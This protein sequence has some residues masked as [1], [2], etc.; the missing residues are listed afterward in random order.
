M[1][2]PLVYRLSLASVL[3]LITM[4]SISFTIYTLYEEALSEARLNLTVAAKS[5][6]RLINS[7]ARFNLEHV[8]SGREG[9]AAAATLDEIRNAHREFHGFAETGEMVVSERLGDRIHFLLWH[10]IDDPAQ[11][12]APSIAWDSANAEPMRRALAGKTGLITALDYR[13]KEVLAAYEPLTALGYGLVIKVDLEEIQS[14]F[15]RAVLI[16]FAAAFVLFAIGTWL[17]GRLTHPLIE[18]TIANERFTSLLLNS[19]AEG[20]YGLDRKGHC[21]FANEASCQLLGYEQKDLL[22]KNLHLLLHHSRADGSPYP[23]SECPSRRAMQAGTV[24]HSE[25]EMLWRR[26]G[27]SMPVDYHVHPIRENGEV[28]GAVVSVVDVSERKN[29]EALLRESE[30]LLRS[31]FNHAAVGIARVSPNGKLLRVNRKFCDILGYSKRSEVQ[32]KSIAEVTHPDDVEKS[33]ATVRAILNGERDTDSMEKRYLRKDGSVIWGAVTISLV[34]SKPDGKP[35]FFIAVLQ[36]IQ[37]R[38]EALA[39]L[40]KSEARLSEAQQVA[41]IGSWELD[42][43]G[44]HLLWSDEVFDIFEIDKEKFDASYEAFLN[45]IHP[46]DREMVNKAYNDSVEKH[47]YY[48]IM[49]R[50]LMSDGR[51]KFVQERGQSFYDEQGKPLRSIGTVQDLT[52]LHEMEEQLQQSQKMEA[53]GTLVGG[54]AHDF[55]NKL[56]AIT[57]NLFLAQEQVKDRPKA[58][59]LL[60]V[61]EEMGFEAADIIAQ[62]LAFARKGKLNKAPLLLVPFLKEASKLNRV[63]IPANIE[64]RLDYGKDQLPVMGDVTQLQQVFLNLVNNA[65]DALEKSENPRIDVALHAV[66]PD[67]AF[68]GRHPD[69]QQGIDYACISVSDNGSGI[70]EKDQPHIFDPFFTTKDVGK[71]TGLGL[72]MVYGVVQKHHGAIEV[73][74][75]AGKGSTFSVY[76]PLSPEAAGSDA[77]KQIEEVEKGQGETVLIADDEPNVLKTLS[78]VLTSLNYKVL[79][80]R[81][82]LEAVEMYGRNAAEID[83]VILD[84]VMPGLMGREAAKRIREIRQDVKLLYCSGHDS[85]GEG[86]EELDGVEVLEKPCVLESMSRTIRQVLEGDA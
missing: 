32:G 34:R 82:G 79:T 24:L 72:A 18:R 29:A 2:N 10:G 4:L 57:G 44:N 37:L 20:I 61:V 60:K 30:E 71:G 53:L 23:E 62:L 9:D 50:L 14:P 3:F 81:D 42:L 74:S 36:N 78:A 39:R 64:Y 12:P 48:E 7:I 35:K 49:H 1:N 75:Q 68:F 47:S 70:A 8:A 77:M 11:P 41:Q 69:L 22:G 63:A 76:L 26:D 16:S 73:E 84:V 86:R 83:L 17:F 45:A 13:G 46:E 25:N 54:I 52:R 19:A 5:Q 67:Q 85:R 27:T 58:V 56:A 6:A 38:K 51:I 31:T 21:T 80:A 65:R 33:M 55:N 66:E 43:V 40:E 15:I 59:E 28:T